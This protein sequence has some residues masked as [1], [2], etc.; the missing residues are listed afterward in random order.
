M[1]KILSIDTETTGL[2]SFRDHILEFGYALFEDGVPTKSGSIFINHGIQIPRESTLI[3]G[4]T[5]EMVSADGLPPQD[6][7]E[8]ILEIFELGDCICGQN[9]DFDIGFLLA[10]NSPVYRRLKRNKPE[11]DTLKIARKFI[12]NKTLRRKGLGSICDFFGVNL[13]GAHRA[14]HDCIATG[15]VLFK[16]ADRLGVSIEELQSP[17]L[18][19]LGPYAIGVDPFEATL[20]GYPNK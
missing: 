13:T 6:A 8:K 17:R 1:N 2:D 4:I 18:T 19:S 15:E 12:P 7:G 10:R 16:M 20:M 11:I 5:E 9:L 14:F 3:H